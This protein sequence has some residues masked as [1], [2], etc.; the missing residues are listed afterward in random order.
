MSTPRT[1]LWRE[2]LRTA[3]AERGAKAALAR[4]LCD[5]DE[6]R[7]ATRKVQIAKVLNQGAV[8]EAEFVL[9]AEE[10]MIGQKAKHRRKTRA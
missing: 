9:A 6:T 1:D 7:L 5:G 2:K 10:W 3:L 4:L 8:P